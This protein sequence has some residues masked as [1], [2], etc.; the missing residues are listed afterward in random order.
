VPRKGALSVVSI[1]G[2]SRLRPPPSLSEIER[3]IFVDLVATTKPTHFAASDLPLLVRYCESA[4][5][6]DQAAQHLRDEGPVIAGRVS[7]W[8]VAQEKS[9]RALT[10]LSMRLRLSPQARAP[11]N[12]S[13]A[14]QPV[15]HYEKMRL[16]NDED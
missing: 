3:A 10:A 4:A 7:P 5:L 15:S 16:Q 1:D 9:I 8:L 13:R 2:R 6:A 11:N 14:Q 12:P